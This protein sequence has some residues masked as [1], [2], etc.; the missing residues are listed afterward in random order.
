MQLPVANRDLLYEHKF[1][2]VSATTLGILGGIAFGAMRQRYNKFIVF[3]LLCIFI[4]P[5]FKELQYRIVKQTVVFNKYIFKGKY[6]YHR[7]K[8][9]NELYQWIIENTPEDS[10]FIDSELMIPIF[11]RR[12]LFIGINKE[13]GIEGYIDMNNHLDKI[14]AYD[15]GLLKKRRKIMEDIYDINKRLLGEE[16]KEFLH[17]RKNIYIS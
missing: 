10:I 6:I 5:L 3:I 17:S 8:E 7:D 11:A 12:Q 15:A 9:E 1:L 13:E 4:L 14:C 2:I 16:S